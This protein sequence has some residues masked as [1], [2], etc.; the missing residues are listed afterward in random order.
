M[1]DEQ[2]TDRSGRKQGIPTVSRVCADQTL[3]E[4]VYDAAKRT[5]GLAV[6]RFGGLWNIEQEIRIETGETLVPYSPRNNLISNE[7]VLL[8][9]P[10]R[11][12]SGWPE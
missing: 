11:L 12:C 9:T 7:C 5:T 10:E 3:V 1:N 2:Q 6:S 4:L 8:S